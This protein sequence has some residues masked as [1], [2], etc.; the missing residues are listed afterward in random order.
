MDLATF[1]GVSPYDR[2]RYG[3]VG[4]SVQELDRDQLQAALEANENLNEQGIANEVALRVK[5]GQNLPYGARLVRQEQNVDA[6]GQVTFQDLPHGI[7]VIVETATPETTVM[8]QEALPLLVE[9]PVTNAEGT[10]WLNEVHLYPKNQVQDAEVTLTKYQQL[11]GQANASLL[12]GAVFDLYE[13]QPG[14]GTLVQAGLTTDENGQITV[15]G[16]TAGTSYYFVETQTED[17]LM[18]NARMK[19]DAN[20][21]LTFTYERNGSISYPEASLLNPE[22]GNEVVNYEKPNVT[23]TAEFTVR[24]DGYQQGQDV[25]Y[26]VDIQVPHDIADYTTFN[27]VDKPEQIQGQP[28][29]QV[30][31]DTITI[32]GLTEG[33]DYSVTRIQ[34]VVLPLNL[35][36]IMDKLVKICLPQLVKLQNLAIQP[37]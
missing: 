12:P 14:N 24:R 27:Y 32:Q 22:D 18:L 16:L 17:N 23:K 31:T 28:S 26:T 29:L 19:N 10:G 1:G 7:Y 35:S 4:F 30:Y 11:N 5:D 13:G 21:L 6:D 15:T 3:D 20:N 34:M 9:L 2:D 8:R 36:L 33:R 37:K 25:D